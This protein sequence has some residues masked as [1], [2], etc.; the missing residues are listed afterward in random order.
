MKKLP[1]FPSSELCVEYMFFNKQKSYQQKSITLIKV[2]ICLFNRYG[3]ARKTY[4]CPANSCPS[5][6]TTVTVYKCP[7]DR[8]D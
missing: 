5:G 2:Y 7:L 6:V 1:R 8:L 3:Y 4:S